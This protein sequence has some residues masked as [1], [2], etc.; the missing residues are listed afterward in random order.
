MPSP[1]THPGWGVALSIFSDYFGLRGLFPQVVPA[2]QGWV[3]GL[4]PEVLQ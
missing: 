4:A 1:E 3:Y 2:L